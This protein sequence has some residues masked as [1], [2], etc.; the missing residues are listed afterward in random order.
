MR[1]AIGLVLLCLPAA[2]AARQSAGREEEKEAPKG[3]QDNSFLMEEAYNQEEGIVQH[4]NSFQRFRGGDWLANFTQ[5]WPVP[6]QAHQLSY[7][8]P[9]ARVDSDT[10]SHTGLGDLALN[11]RYQLAGSGE[12]KFACAPRFSVLLPTGDQ[13]RDLGSGGVGF[14]V[15]VAMSTVLSKKFVMHTNVGGTWNPRAKDAAGDTAATLGWNLGQSFIWLARN[16]LNFLVETIWNEAQA[17]VDGRQVAASHALT[18]SPGLRWAWNRPG[19]GLQIVPGIA[20]PI[21]IGAN[22]TEASVFVYLSF[23]HEMWKR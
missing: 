22:R 18:V 9:Y 2:L 13:R 21:G 12:A 7:T 17:V 3:I 20:V 16:D 10:V 23:E 5:E 15:N 8:V 6:R 11:Y 4:I 19:G 1:W 14:Q